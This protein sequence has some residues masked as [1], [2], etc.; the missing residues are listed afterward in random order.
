M[1][2]IKKPAIFL[3][4]VCVAV[5]MSAGAL[6]SAEEDTTEDLSYALTEQSGEA[7]Q[8]DMEKIAQF[9]DEQQVTLLTAG[10]SGGY[11]RSDDQDGTVL[12]QSDQ[13]RYAFIQTDQEVL[14]WAGVYGGDAGDVPSQVLYCQ[15]EGG[16]DAEED[17]LWLDLSDLTAQFGDQLQ[18]Q[19]ADPGR[20]YSIISPE[21]GGEYRVE[22]RGE[23]KYVFLSLGSGSADERFLWAGVFTEEQA[24]S[25][26]KLVF[27]TVPGLVLPG[28]GEEEPSAPTAVPQATQQPAL[29]VQVK[30]F[31]AV[32]DGKV[33]SPSVSVEDLEC[34]YAICPSGET[35]EDGDWKRG[36]PRLR[37]VCSQWVYVRVGSED[38]SVVYVDGNGEP[39]SPQRDYVK[40]M[41]RVLPAPVVLD[42]WGEQ[43]GQAVYDGR[44]QT[45]HIHLQAEVTED[46]SGLYALSALM[47]SDV[48]P[49][50]LTMSG[51]D[52]GAYAVAVPEQL[53]AI[54][55]F[56]PNYDVE[57]QWRDSEAV[58]EPRPLELQSSSACAVFEP[59][60]GPL[61]ASDKVEGVDGIMDSDY[62]SGDIFAAGE[63][64]GAGVSR[65][66]IQLDPNGTFQTRKEN[67]SFDLDQSAGVL[68]M[69]PQSISQ[70]DTSW[71]EVSDEID[72]ALYADAQPEELPGYYTGMH[73]ELEQTQSTYDG[74]AKAVSVLFRDKN[75]RTVDL[76]E[77]ED[78][79]IEFFRQG[80]PTADLVSTGT[81]TVRLSGM[82]SYSGQVELPYEILPGTLPD[83][84]IFIDSWTYDGLAAG[85]EEHPVIVSVGEPIISYQ[86]ENGQTV[87]APR[88]AGSYQA[89]AVWEETEQTLE[90]SAVCTFSIAPAVV[91]VHVGEA[92]KIYGDDDPEI[93]MTVEGAAENDMPDFE[94]TRQSGEDCGSY[95]AR[96]RTESENYLIT[97]EP[98]T[99]TILPRPVEDLEAE[100]VD[101]ALLVTDRGAALEGG[102]DYT[103]ETTAD[104]EHP[105]EELVELVGRGNYTGRLSLERR[106]QPISVSLGDVKAEAFSRTG[107][108]FGGNDTMNCT[109]TIVLSGPAEQDRLSVSI[110]GV[111]AEAVLEP[112]DGQSYT[113]SVNG[114]QLADGTAKQAELSVEVDGERVCAQAVSLRNERQILAWECLAGGMAL[115]AAVCLGICLHT[116]AQLRRRGGHVPRSSERTIQ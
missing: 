80:E 9:Y 69:F 14:L 38:G 108:L 22:F 61:T 27:H 19:A 5:L 78:F 66:E 16:S 56:D 23:R 13:E 60:D 48:W 58:I 26:G 18:L 104:G 33:H 8:L 87:D 4:A 81:V 92:E 112:V 101:G 59:F 47:E 25:S 114:F 75:G 64:T 63:Q 98:G 10:A 107:I 12:L 11:V 50:E 1:E 74:T 97:C 105:G 71:D 15:E 82:G 54:R 83:A 90:N 110:D 2:H 20:V 46:E 24:K 68:V 93:P 28:G 34:F 96:I 52:A 51:V 21:T 57:I 30:G 32:F 55:D 95:E 109:G 85:S 76:A 67:Y 102:V 43:D 88:D 65:N 79:S 91:T 35:P 3:A 103:V 6:A 73:V 41:C 17:C 89:V 115:C 94:V 7:A 44:E 86:D 111:D 100:W 40:V 36:L 29:K 113:F 45:L 49:D 39:L 53:D 99:L 42:V 84:G 77:G 31:S 116:A 72:P 106:A 37:D 70:S 62:Y